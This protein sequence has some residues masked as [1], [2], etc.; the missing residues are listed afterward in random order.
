MKGI[1][2]MIAVILLIAFTIGVG[3][4]VSI[5][6]TGL[7]KTTTGLTSNQSES[8]S[9]CGGAWINVYRVTNTTVFYQNPN[10]EA[11]TGLTVIMS[12]GTI[13]LNP[14]DPRLAT[15]ESNYTLVGNSSSAANSAGISGVSPAGA[16]GN[17]SVIVRGLCE[18]IITV[19]GTCK[20]GQGCWEI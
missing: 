6:A 14:A 19:E 8:L 18:S 10:R 16:T 17:T 11:V 4:L 9:R 7:T 1:S 5:F 13:N 12:D 20:R 15:G 2:P 3:G